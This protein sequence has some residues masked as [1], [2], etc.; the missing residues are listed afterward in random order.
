MPPGITI[1]GVLFIRIVDDVQVRKRTETVGDGL[2]DLLLRFFFF[3]GWC[4]VVV[5]PP[6]SSLSLSLSLSWFSREGVC[7]MRELLP[8][9]SAFYSRG[10]APPAGREDQLV[11]SRR[12]GPPEVLL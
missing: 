9:S 4:T 7:V 6:S 1:P 2:L 8:P 10:D 12:L 11:V 5:L 3:L